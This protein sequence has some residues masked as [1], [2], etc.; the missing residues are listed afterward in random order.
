MFG[1]NLITLIGFLVGGLIG[2]YILSLLFRNALLGRSATK[3]TRVLVILL[4][5][6]VAIGCLG[7][8]SG[9]GGFMDRISNPPDLFGAL[10][11]ILSAVIIGITVAFAKTRNRSER[12]Q[13]ERPQKTVVK[14]IAGVIAFP[15]TFIGLG[16]ITVNAY[17]AAAHDV[18]P[19]TVGSV[20]SREQVR[21]SMLNGELA[22]FWRMLNE[23]APADLARI[24]DGFFV[25]GKADPTTDDARRQLTVELLDYQSSL[26]P[27]GSALT[28]RQRIEMLQSRVLLLNATRDNPRICSDLAVTGGQELSQQDLQSIADGY[29]RM[30]MTTVGNLL[31]ARASP[32]A[33]T[34]PPP[35]PSEADYLLLMQKLMQAGMR[36]EQ[37]DAIGLADASHPDYCVALADYL[38]AVA[39]LD[40]PSGRAIRY[41]TVQLMMSPDQ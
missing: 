2:T 26:A 20:Q 12:P 35:T 22:P 37:L 18:R 6:L 41:E 31:E 24:I 4:A 28:D 27:H 40:G 13:P 1:Y 29:N 34:A 25:A 32:P 30:M 17:N 19:W 5:G 3:P 15:L 7:F 8:A 36:E 9:T 33:N 14:Y 11:Y 39:R 10:C 21:Q 16:N 23:Q 38:A